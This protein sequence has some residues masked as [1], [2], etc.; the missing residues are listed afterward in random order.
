MVIKGYRGTAGHGA[1]LSVIRH[2]YR[3]GVLRNDAQYSTAGTNRN[4][5]LIVADESINP[6]IRLREGVNMPILEDD[7]A[8]EEV[9][10][11][12]PSKWDMDYCDDDDD[13]FGTGG[14]K[15]T[16][17][18]VGKTKQEKINDYWASLADRCFEIGSPV[19]ICTPIL[20]YATHEHTIT[21][22]LSRAAQE[23]DLQFNHTCG[24]HVHVGCG[25]G[26]SWS[27]E[28]LKA[29]GKATVLWEGKNSIPSD[30]SIYRPSQYITC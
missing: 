28:E 15:I 18:R 14:K 2:L 13:G 20:G 22:M 27:L 23:L 21:V 25:K 30:S 7:E 8:L 16:I 3:T 19:E 12:A 17:K 26:S 10:D 5:F 11:M 1:L 6:R 9:L 29:I 24:L 4:K